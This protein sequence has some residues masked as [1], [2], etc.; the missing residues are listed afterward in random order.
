MHTIETTRLILR[1]FAYDDLDALAEINRDPQVIRFIGDGKPQSSEKSATRLNEYLEHERR[2]AFGFWAAVEKTT[3]E[4]VGFCGL[5]FLENSGEVEVGYRL[6]RRV[7]GMGLA[8]ESAT[9]SLQYGFTE[10]ELDRI[11][12]VI[13][14]EN[15]ASQRVVEKLGLSYEKDARFYGLDLKY[16]AIAREAYAPDG[17]H[18]LCTSSEI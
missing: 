15:I 6:A 2:H 7:W 4:M 16:Y 12:A 18:Y 8:T 1:P 5:Q 13:H 9:A 14:P 17:S 10:L 3:R 11:V